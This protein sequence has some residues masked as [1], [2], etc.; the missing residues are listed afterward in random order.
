MSDGT[1][2]R[3]VDFISKL[4]PVYIH[5]FDGH[6][7]SA[8]SLSSGT[9][10]RPIADPVADENGLVEVL[11]QG[12]VHNSS[13]VQGV[14]VAQ[15]AVVQYLEHHAITRPGKT[16]HE[17]LRLEEHFQ[18]KTGESLGIDSDTGGNVLASFAGD[19]IK[20]L[21]V[22]GAIELIKKGIGL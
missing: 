5:E 8:R 12:A 19:L 15:L 20:K 4:I 11:W 10:I 21:G 1:S 7:V 9:L 13:V 17:L 14:F 2:I 22:Q 16:H 18:V 6:T 3:I